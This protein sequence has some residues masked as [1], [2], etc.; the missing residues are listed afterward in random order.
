PSNN[1]YGVGLGFRC[2]KTA[3]P[4]IELQI[5]QAHT[6]ALV[7]MGRENNVEARQAIARGLALDPRDADLLELRSLIE[8]AKKP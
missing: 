2:A 5:K 8:Q 3:P 4:E 6:M 1:S 7:E